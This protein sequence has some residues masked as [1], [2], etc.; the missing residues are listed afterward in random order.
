M[1]FD[2]DP[3]KA[4]RI[5]EKRGIALGDIAKLFAEEHVVMRS[6]QNGEERWK[7][8]GIIDEVFVT[9][10]YTIRIG[11]T[12]IITARRAWRKEER[13]HRELHS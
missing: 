13:A 8:V 3:D 11:V 5:L 12:R 2:W 1:K 4:A 9:G 7:I 10:I 6:D